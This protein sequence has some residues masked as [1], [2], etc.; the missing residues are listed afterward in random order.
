MRSL[1]GSVD[2][3][4]ALSFRRISISMDQ[5]WIVTIQWNLFVAPQQI[6]ISATRNADDLDWN[7]VTVWSSK[8]SIKRQISAMCSMKWKNVCLMEFVIERHSKNINL[9]PSCRRDAT[10][11]R[12]KNSLRATR[13]FVESKIKRQ[14]KKKRLTCR[15]IDAFDAHELT[16]YRH[17]GGPLTLISSPRILFTVEIENRN[18][19]CW[20]RI[21]NLKNSF[22]TS[23][24]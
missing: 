8:R 4:S 9:I 1:F 7:D 5:S 3:F 2:F 14:K 6:E 22:K 18:F 19:W 11:K 12:S 16:H 15:S 10:T 13:E 21:S 24:V 23:C 20:A 17:S